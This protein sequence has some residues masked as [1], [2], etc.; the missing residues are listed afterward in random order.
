MKWHPTTH[1]NGDLA[2]LWDKFMNNRN[3]KFLLFYLWGH[4][5][6]F[7]RQN[8]WD[9]IENFC[10]LTG[11]HENIWYVTNIE[12]VDYMNAL[13]RIVFSKDET[14]I[15]NTS[16][17]DVWITANGEPVSSSLAVY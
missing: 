11:G 13:S 2:T 7:D 4:S 8:N 17:I 15:Q 10:N 5:Y 14:M 16:A 12:I 9:V 6:E 1:H 3:D